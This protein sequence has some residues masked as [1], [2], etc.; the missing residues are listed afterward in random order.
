MMI[1]LIIHLVDELEICGP[2]GA[3]WCYPME[4]YLLILKNKMKNRAKPK[5]C[6]AF[7]YMYDKALGFYTKYFCNLFAHTSPHVGR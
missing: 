3:M 1:H 5:A 2:V 4:T 6:M 7:G